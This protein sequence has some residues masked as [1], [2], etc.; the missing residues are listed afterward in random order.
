MQ[1]SEIIEKELLPEEVVL[2]NSQPNAS[3]IFTKYDIF[4]VPFSILWFGFAIF[5][6]I[7]ASKAGGFLGAFGIP[8]LFLGAYMSV[9]RFFVKKQT[10]SHLY[11]IITNKRVI[12]INTNKYGE[13]RRMVASSLTSIPTES[14]S[15]RND[16]TGS[17]IFGQIPF[18]QAIY[19]NSGMEFF[20]GSHQ[21]SVT[22]FF[23]IE[24]VK[25]VYQVYKNAK[26]SK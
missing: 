15:Y 21:N 2:W 7:G 14:I 22:A 9:G 19:M 1:S 6:V 8:F 23:D 13:I 5:W 26:F 11:Y 20:S 10:K 25:E 18:Q 12:C 24:N 3:K 17:I 4:F 16:G